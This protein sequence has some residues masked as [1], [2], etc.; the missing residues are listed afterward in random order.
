MNRRFRTV[1]ALLIIS[2]AL[3]A[4]GVIAG[5]PAAVFGKAAN[6]CL[7]CFGMG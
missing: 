3:F 2:A 1:W 6:I 5:Q 7:E 4:A